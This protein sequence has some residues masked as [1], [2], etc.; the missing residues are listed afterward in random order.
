MLT[1]ISYIAGGGGNHLKNLMSLDAGFANSPDL[2]KS[3]YYDKPEQPPGTVHSVGGRNISQDII[4]QTQLHSSS[5]WLLHG[6]WGELMPYRTQLS[7][8]DNRWLLLSL[9]HEHDRFLVSTRHDRLHQ[10]PHPYWLDEEQRYLYQ[11]EMYVHY[12]QAQP[13]NIYSLSLSEFWHPDLAHNDTLQKINNFFK[14]NIDP[15]QAQALHTKWWEMNFN[16]DFDNRVRNFYTT[17]NK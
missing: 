10:H 9:D 14:I 15:V 7:A 13:H 11:P 12:F 3:V 16:F 17:A 8:P 5:S 4:D 1:I 2:N 6:H